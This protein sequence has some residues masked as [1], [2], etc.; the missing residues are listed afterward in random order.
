MFIYCYVISRYFKTA[1]SLWRG[2]GVRTCQKT[3]TF[4]QPS[5]F[6][7]HGCVQKLPDGIVGGIEG[8]GK[9]NAPLYTG[10]YSYLLHMSLYTFF[11]FK[12]LWCPPPNWIHKFQMNLRYNISKSKL[13]TYFNLLVLQLQWNMMYA[14]IHIHAHGYLSTLHVLYMLRVS[15]HNAINPFP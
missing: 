6:S 8:T 4:W 15:G 11:I 1:D 3:I 9:T 5:W 12:A 10:S 2:C 14:Y 7:L 13:Q